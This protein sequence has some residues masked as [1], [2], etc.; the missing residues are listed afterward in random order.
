MQR[1]YQSLSEKWQI[2][3]TLTQLF[4]PRSLHNCDLPHDL[5]GLANLE[6]VGIVKRCPLFLY[7]Q[8]LRLL[9]GSDDSRNHP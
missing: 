7:S 2:Q 1:Y 9:Y 3:L 8:R 5:A 4:N 6:A